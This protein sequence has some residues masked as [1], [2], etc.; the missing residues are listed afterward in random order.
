MAYHTYDNVQVCGYVSKVWHSDAL[1]IIDYDK[2]TGVMTFSNAPQYDFVN[3][4]TV[5]QAIINN[6]SEELDDKGEYWIDA[7]NK[8]LYVYKPEGSYSM[9]TKDTFLTIPRDV[10][11]ITFKKLNFRICNG[12]GIRSDGDDFTMDMCSLT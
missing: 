2:S 12:I 4:D 9:A 10:N 1:N 5:Q 3:V 11:N 8:V 6:V 7:E